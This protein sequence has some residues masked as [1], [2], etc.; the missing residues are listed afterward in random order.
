[1][2]GNNLLVLQKHRNRIAASSALG[3]LLAMTENWR[4]YLICHCDLELVS[5]EAISYVKH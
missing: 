4:Q 3:R 1:M 5:G 2:Q